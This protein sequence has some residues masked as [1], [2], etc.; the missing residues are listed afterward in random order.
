MFL[1]IS[2]NLFLTEI[3]GSIVIKN[4]TLEKLI[5]KFNFHFYFGI[6]EHVIK[7]KSVFNNFLKIQIR[8]EQYLMKINIRDYD[9]NI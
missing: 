4:W 9:W 8:I 5:V 3:Y 1:L 6:S 2:F 7:L